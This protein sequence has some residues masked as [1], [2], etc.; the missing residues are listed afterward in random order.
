VTASSAAVRSHALQ[1]ALCLIVV[2]VVVLAVIY[3]AWIAIGNFS[4]IS[5]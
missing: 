1:R 3:A 2:V 5:V 4:R